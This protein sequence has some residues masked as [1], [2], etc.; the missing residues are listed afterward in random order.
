MVSTTQLL[1]KIHPN[2]P[3]DSQEDEDDTV[4]TPLAATPSAVELIKGGEAET[5]TISGGSGEYTATTSDEAITAT[6]NGS[7]VTITAGL[8]ADETSTVTISDGTDEVTIAITT[9]EE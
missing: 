7:T 3:D 5:V 6:V 1:T 9:T 2:T 4:T 8:L